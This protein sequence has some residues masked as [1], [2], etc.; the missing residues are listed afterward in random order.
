VKQYLIDFYSPQG[1]IDFEY[2]ENEDYVLCDCQS[3]DLIFQKRIP[4][5]KLMEILYGHWLDSD[6]IFE[7]FKLKRTRDRYAHYASEIHTIGS[8]FRADPPDI[9]L[10]DFGMGWGDWLLMAQGFGYDCFGME[11]S[12]GKVEYA[13][14]RGLK[15]L[16]W[17]DAENLRFDFINTEQVFEHIPEPLETLMQ[18][19]TL[20][21]T[22]GLIK[23]SVPR[24]NNVEKLLGL[25]D[26]TAKKGTSN[27]LNPL[28]P[29]EH[30]QYFKRSSMIRMAELAGMSE[31]KIPLINQWDNTFGWFYPKGFVR[32]AFLP[33]YRNLLG[34]S[35]YIFLTPK[36]S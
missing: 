5:S 10:L 21:K 13:K 34:S 18:L 14:S 26:W 7:N 23:I 33:L 36:N 20:L 25:M 4:N 29:L 32:N 27:S 30:I 19:K 28:A 2:L 31:V 1:G 15:V 8:Y 11:L 3:C 17:E 16:G 9:T 6:I 35:N 24:A 22:N 12:K